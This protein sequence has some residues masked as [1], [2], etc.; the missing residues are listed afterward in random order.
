M[1]KFSIHV[2]DLGN[3][4]TISSKVIHHKEVDSL[5]QVINEVDEIIKRFQI[6]L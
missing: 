1:H 3:G 4:E 6:I 2:W 5:S